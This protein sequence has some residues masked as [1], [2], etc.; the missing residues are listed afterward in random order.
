VFNEA[1]A[2]EALRELADERPGLAEEPEAERAPAAAPQ[3]EPRARRGRLLVAAAAVLA[4]GLAG[5]LYAA[6]Q[7]GAGTVG[8]LWRSIV[9]LLQSGRSA[10]S[11]VSPGGKP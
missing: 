2:R 11:D 1:F 5:A 9:K 4:L 6:H 7:E 10:A 8:G 3:R